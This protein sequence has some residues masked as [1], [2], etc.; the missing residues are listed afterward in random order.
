[1]K[2]VYAKGSPS[3]LKNEAARADNGLGK[4][5]STW[6]KGYLKPECSMT[7]VPSLGKF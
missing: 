1:M 6:F 4:V 3:T 2:K 7:K 5:D